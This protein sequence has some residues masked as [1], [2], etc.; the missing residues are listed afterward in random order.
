MGANTN[1]PKLEPAAG[2]EHKQPQQHEQHSQAKQQQP[3][4]SKTQVVPSV[5]ATDAAQSQS[6][7][8]DALQAEEISIAWKATALWSV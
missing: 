6:V 8:S 2:K 7:A 3:I 1:E 4:S 5:R